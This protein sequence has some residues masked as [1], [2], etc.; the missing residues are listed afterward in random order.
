MDGSRRVVIISIL[1]FWLNGLIL[2]Y[3]TDK[4]YWVDVKYYV[5]ECVNLDGFFRRIVIN[6]GNRFM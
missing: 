2:D 5:I 3:V 6:I 4:L 1:L